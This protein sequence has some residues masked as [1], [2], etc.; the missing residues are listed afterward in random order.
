MKKFKNYLWLCLTALFLSQQMVLAQGCPPP[1]NFAVDITKGT[2]P[3][4]NLSWSAP[5]LPNSVVGYLITYTLDAN[6]PVAVPL[7]LS[8]TAYSVPLSQGWQSLEVHIVSVCQDGSVSTPDSLRRRYILIEDLVLARSEVAIE[9][10]VCINP[11]RGATHF[12]NAGSS[13]SI[14][15]QASPTSILLWQQWLQNNSSSANIL[16]VQ[17]IELFNIRNFCGCMEENNNDFADYDFV[18][19]C[20]L[21][22]LDVITT[23]SNVL[24]YCGSSVIGALQRES[25]KSNEAIS[26]ISAQLVPNPFQDRLQVLLPSKQD[27]TIQ[28][29]LFMPDGRQAM[30]SPWLQWKEGQD[31]WFDV[32]ALAS[33][34]YF[35]EILTKEGERSIG[36]VLKTD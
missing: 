14:M 5:A 32:S 31:T 28:L 2:P 26:T 4:A 9:Q 27:Q 29:S 23:N 17:G 22:S 7:P 12:R 25:N 1:T 11:C 6:P 10:K 13:S 35:Y 34:L 24:S 16:S 3:I 30:V 20:K 33:G 18:D 8:P 15:T 21:R 19:Y 36:K